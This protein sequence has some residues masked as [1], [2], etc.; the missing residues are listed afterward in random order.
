MCLKLGA[1][2]LEI[3]L[4]L[5]FTAFIGYILGEKT[6][7]KILDEYEALETE[8][9]EKCDFEPDNETLMRLHSEKVAA[10]N[11]YESHLYKSMGIP[12]II[13]LI[14]VLTGNAFWQ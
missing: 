13:G 11:A 7:K 8:I 14:I 1:T 4:T 10:R 5:I 9:M 2:N 3:I 12:S 6:G